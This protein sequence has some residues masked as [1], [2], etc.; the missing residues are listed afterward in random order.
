VMVKKGI[1]CIKI[2]FAYFNVL[3]LQE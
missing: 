3:S 1:A 2:D